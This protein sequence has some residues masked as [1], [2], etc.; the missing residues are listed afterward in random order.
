MIA[1]DAPTSISVRVRDRAS[2]DRLLNEAISRMADL[3]LTRHTDGILVTRHT[4]EYFTVRLSAKV[5]FGYTNEHD[6]RYCVD[7]CM[8][9]EGSPDSAENVSARQDR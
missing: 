2:M 3:A 6:C 4:D 5:P 8:H 1:I 9:T 7:T